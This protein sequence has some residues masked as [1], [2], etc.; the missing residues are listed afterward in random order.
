MTLEQ[1]TKKRSVSIDLARPDQHLPPA[2][3]A[4][5][6]VG[7][8][9]MLVAGQRMADQDGVGLVAR[10]ACRRSGRRS[11]TATAARRRRA[12]AAG[13]RRSAAPGSSGRRP[14]CLALRAHAATID[15]QSS[16]IAAGN[17]K[18]A[19]RSQSR[20]PCKRPFSDLFNVA[21]SRP[22]KSPR[23]R[24]L[25]LRPAALAVNG[26][27][28]RWTHAAS[29]T[30]E[31]SMT[32]PAAPRAR[33]QACM[34]IAAYVPGKSDGAGRRREGPQAVVQREP[35][36]RRR[37]TA[38]EAVREAGR[39]AGILSRRL[40]DAA[41]RGDRRG[42]RAEPGQHRLLATA[43]TRSSACWRRPICAGRRGHLHRARLSRSTRSTSR[44]PA[45]CRSWRTETDERAD[46]D[47]IL[48]ARDGARR[49]SSSSPTPTTRPAPI[50][51]SRKCAGCMPALPQHVLLV[52]DAAYAEY[53]RRNDYE[54]GI[55][56]VVV[57]A[58][59]RDD[60]HL[61]QD[62]RARRPAHR[63]DATR[64]RTSSTRS[65]AC[66][67]RSTSTPRRSRPASRRSATAPMSSAPSRTTSD[68]CP[69]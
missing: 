54:A 46:V 34:D 39:E 28:F 65:T 55:E 17:K 32:R 20:L 48:A 69:G 51:R 26:E 67:G 58:E 35:A 63:L 33:A 11:G 6:R 10:S 1:M 31:I 49:G 5:H 60:A 57:V 19:L 14:R 37:P 42:A 30:S 36:R 53:V 16:R 29:P 22:A 41:A 21:A 7:A 61:L 43:P 44:P 24:F 13:R 68:G 56:L 66:A 12:A 18:P 23:N 15:L 8:G 52:L 9:D 50:C 4:G 40:G 62:P 3:L 25:D 27:C 64:R 45:A 38:I 2:G 47:A 59:C